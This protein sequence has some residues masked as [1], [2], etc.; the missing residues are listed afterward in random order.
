[1]STL[2]QVSQQTINLMKTAV[3]KAA[4]GGFTTVTGASGFDLAPFV[5][6]Y[7]A[8]TPFYN[9]TPRVQVAQGGESAVW[10]TYLNT[11]TAQSYG[12]TSA[13]TAGPLMQNNISTQLAI[14]TQTAQRQ[15]I[16]L[17]AIG[18]AMNYVDVYSLAVTEMLMAKIVTED[19]L[20]LNAVS[21]S[22]GSPATPTLTASTTGGTIAA[23][24]DVSVQV[25]F[26][27]GWNWYAGGSTAASTAASVTTASTTATNSV[28]AT[29]AGAGVLVS[30]YDWYVG[31]YYYTTTQL[32]TVTITSV[33]T[34]N[35]A[36]PNVVGLPLLWK[37]GQ[38]AIT[39]VPSAD[40]SYVSTGW[41]GLLGSIVADLT[42]YGTM[43]APASYVA[44]GS[45]V[46]QGAYVDN[47]A[48]GQLTSDGPQ[49]T[50]FNAAFEAIYSVW[51][52]SPTRILMAPQQFNDITTGILGTVNAVNY[53]E[54][55]SISQHKGLVASG[56]VPV[57]INPITG[58]AVQ[59]QV[60]PHLPPGQ[61]AIV[62][63][64]IPFPASNI[65]SSLQV[66][67]T[68]DNFLFQYG[69][70]PDGTSGSGPA[71]KVEVRSQESFV[72][73]AAPTMGVIGGIAPGLAA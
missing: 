16:S 66:R 63:D 72:N 10:Q 3:A 53:F 34:A 1:M 42:S 52:I 15:D 62:C 67:T 37:S 29:V 19:I 22:V 30:A 9:S 31:G 35:Q 71:W 69:V 47:L 43:S 73:A 70:V 54:P 68:Y 58:D 24:T 2:A 12:F 44:P 32:P 51:Q 27:S 25:A 13:N 18:Q 39:S 36:I 20:M 41:T 6:L 64:Q 23:S 49:I 38:V 59:L 8:V 17:D 11:Q 56:S 45:G 7:P 4:T 28:T 14:Y 65:G 57:Y 55:T 21:F 26:R 48:G 5:S 50:Q 60:M 46:S 33:P 40:T 61:V